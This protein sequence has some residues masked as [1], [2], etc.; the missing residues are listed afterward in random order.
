M[1]FHPQLKNG[2]NP[3]KL[4]VVRGVIALMHFDSLVDKFW[5]DIASRLKLKQV[6]VC[7]LAQ[8]LVSLHPDA[9]GQAEALLIFANSL[10]R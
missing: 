6:I 9:K 5:P 2:E 10:F 7:K 1:S 4:T 3:H 8:G